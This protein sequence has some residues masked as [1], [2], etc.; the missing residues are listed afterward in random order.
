VHAEPEAATNEPQPD[1]QHES[2][3]DLA[4]EQIIDDL[5]SVMN[6]GDVAHSNNWVIHGKHTASGR[7][8]LASDPHLG[9]S[10]PSI[11]Q[12]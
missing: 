9:T 4:K 1:E 10:I 7:P 11:W 12:L 2:E 8:L 6:L 5:E 3:S